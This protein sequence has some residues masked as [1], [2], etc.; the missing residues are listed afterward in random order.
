MQ[1][2]Q[3]NNAGDQ[4]AD[5]TQPSQMQQAYQTAASQQPAAQPQAPQQQQAPVGGLRGLMMRGRAP[6]SK[7]SNGRNLA[8]LTK[9]LTDYKEAAQD[10]KDLDIKIIPVARN[11]VIANNNFSNQISMIVFALTNENK[12]AYHTLLLAADLPPAP[13]TRNEQYGYNIE[14]AAAP[15]TTVALAD[16]ALAA[17][18][19]QKVTQVFPQTTLYS[20]DWNTVPDSFRMNDPFAIE[21]LFLNSLRACWEELMSKE[22]DFRY[23]S[24][25]GSAGDNTAVVSIHFNQDQANPPVDHTD[26]VG[27]PIRSEIVVDFRSEQPRSAAKDMLTENTANVVE[28]GQAYAYVTLGI[29]PV[30]ARQ[31]QWA[32]PGTGANETQEYVGEV[33]ISGIDLVG[34]IDLANVLLMIS[35]LFPVLDSHSR[36]WLRNFLPR[37]LQ[38]NTGGRS[39]QFRPRD[40]G[41]L[42]FDYKFKPAGQAI[43]EPF[44]TNDENEFNIE[45]FNWLTNSIIQPGAALSID[46]PEVGDQTWFLRP[47][48][49]ATEVQQAYDAIVKAAD[50]LTDGR[51]SQIFNQ[52]Q[53]RLIM[54]PRTERVLNGFYLDEHGVQKDIRNIDML[55]MLNREGHQ[56][57]EIGKQW[58]ATFGGGSDAQLAARAK[59][60]DLVVTN[61]TYTG[62]SVHKTF[63][64]D[65]LTSLDRA[66]TQTG[67]KIRNEMS[68]EDSRLMAR[69]IAGLA[70][71]GALM[72]NFQSGMFTTGGYQTTGAGYRGMAHTRRY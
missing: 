46:V 63:H 42:N 58:M 22:S 60:I 70:S 12:C 3:V 45:A 71:A 62:I 11:S 44:N 21:D 17:V 67:L 65:F 30:A 36:P 2:N 38:H 35:T 69:P 41:A 64:P 53:T 47:F 39:S 20:A 51:F 6:G 55:Y 29:D 26:K 14:T 54:L 66:I 4:K 27:L 25:S 37:H 9:K 32:T 43:V 18:I 61:V 5:T 50:G 72:T 8:E 68:R 24:L 1:G 7:D 52:T 59:L 49:E 33:T 15:R 23:D 48:A 34:K 31:N 28:F 16:D 13:T 57:P 40:L 19:R 56:N 10:L